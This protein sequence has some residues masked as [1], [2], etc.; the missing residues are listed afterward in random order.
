MYAFLCWCECIF[1]L[2]EIV[3]DFYHSDSFFFYFFFLN[4]YISTH[5]VRAYGVVYVDVV[6]VAVVDDSFSPFFA[7]VFKHICKIHY[8]DVL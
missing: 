7:V 1:I 4:S 3:H 8:M 2:S 5:M 6:D